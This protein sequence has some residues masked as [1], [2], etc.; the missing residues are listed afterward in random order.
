V[1]PSRAE[2]TGP[3]KSA[4]AALANQS[5]RRKNSRLVNACMLAG[6][7]RAGEGPTSTAETAGYS[8][9]DSS[10]STGHPRA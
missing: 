1:S 4:R 8:F 7:A 6:F 10:D 3:E 2:T 5:V 9:P